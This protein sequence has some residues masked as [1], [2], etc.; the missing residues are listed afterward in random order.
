[1]LGRVGF[2]NFLHRQYTACKDNENGKTALN[3]QYNVSQAP[4]L[5]SSLISTTELKDSRWLMCT[6]G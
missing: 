5:S 4:M 3:K 1:M 2:A 6:Q